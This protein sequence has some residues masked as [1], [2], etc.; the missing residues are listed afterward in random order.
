MTNSLQGSPQRSGSRYGTDNPPK[1]R[2]GPSRQLLHLVRRLGMLVESD[3]R[4]LLLVLKQMKNMQLKLQLR[5]KLKYL[6]WLKQ[7][8]LS[9]SSIKKCA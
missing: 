3:E 7:E 6:A 2:G 8:S 4:E 9:V 5:L 1:P